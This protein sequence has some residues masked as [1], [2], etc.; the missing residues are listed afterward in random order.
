MGYDKR[1]KRKPTRF[2]WL[3]ILVNALV[4]LI[5]GIILLILDKMSE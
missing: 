3:V 2:D 5:V 4:D 1:P